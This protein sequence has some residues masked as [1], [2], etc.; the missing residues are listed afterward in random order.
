M[1]F[2]ACFCFG[3][4]SMTTCLMVAVVFNY[5]SHMM[6]EGITV[7]PQIYMHYNSNPV[8]LSVVTA[9]LF[10]IIDFSYFTVQT[11]SVLVL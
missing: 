3:Y 11:S 8:F 10:D 5:F 2:F 4:Q 1:F 7:L 9:R 6:Q